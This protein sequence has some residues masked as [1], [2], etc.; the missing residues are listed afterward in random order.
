MTEAGLFP[1]SLPPDFRVPVQVI[2]LVGKDWHRETWLQ[3]EQPLSLVRVKSFSLAPPHFTPG[4]AA[5]VSVTLP[6]RAAGS[7]AKAQVIFGKDIGQVPHQPLPW[8]FVVLGESTAFCGKAW[9]LIT[10]S[11][12]VQKPLDFC[13]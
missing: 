2:L 8:Y 10:C 6:L 12:Q 3:S 1:G 11:G 7:G 5:Y 13:P 4:K 9:E